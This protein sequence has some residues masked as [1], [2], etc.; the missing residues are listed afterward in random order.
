MCSPGRGAARVRQRNRHPRGA[1]SSPSFSPRIFTSELLTYP[2]CS[3]KWTL[4]LL[5]PFKISTCW[6]TPYGPYFLKSVAAYHLRSLLP[7]GYN[8]IPLPT[9][10]GCKFKG[11]YPTVSRSFLSMQLM[12]LF[13]K[14][15]QSHCRDARLG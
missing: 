12:T 4:Y 1:S 10:D 15:K 5:R 8:E 7:T 3:Y 9:R 11:L 2:S 13:H 6:G 14:V